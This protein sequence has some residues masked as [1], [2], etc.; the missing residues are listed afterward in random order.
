M[1][2]GSTSEVNDWQTVQGAPVDDWQTVTFTGNPARAK[3]QS[4]GGGQRTPAEAAQSRRDAGPPDNLS[5]LS[6]AYHVGAGVQQIGEGVT[7][8]GEPGWEKLGGASDIARGAMQVAAP[9]TLPT[10]LATAPAKTLLGLIMGGAAGGLAEGAA[11]AMGAPPG[12]AE[13]IGTGAGLAGGALGYRLGP[14][15]DTLLNL[16]RARN[17]PNF[18]EAVGNLIPAEYGTKVRKVGKALQAFKYATVEPPPGADTPVAGYQKMPTTQTPPTPAPPELG[19]AKMPKAYTPISPEP[20]IP[21]RYGKMPVA[22]TPGPPPEEPRPP[23]YQKMPMVRTPAEPAPELT[24][25]PAYNRS[26]G[27][28]TPKAPQAEIPEPA[29]APAGPPSGVPAKL[30]EKL[31]SEHREELRGKL[32]VP[33][34]P[35]APTTAGPRTV[36]NT[37]WNEADPRN[38][39]KDVVHWNAQLKNEKMANFYVN[40]HGPEAAAKLE[41]LPDTELIQHLRQN[42]F[43]APRKNAGSTQSMQR[44]LSQVRADIKRE[45]QTRL[46]LTPP[47]GQ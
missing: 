38:I 23:G 8:M 3:R 4:A 22:R 10:S 45:I 13:A 30:W 44:P 19:Y 7:R 5:P 12:A 34:Q 17:D 16:F 36:T 31:S 40:Q 15:N 26:V 2:G 24:P 35:G 27:V 21:T 28:G 6:P 25:P 33:P 11:G 9:F 39:A 37:E 32:E 43:D 47:P 29:P 42:G 20:E 46:R 18:R 41:S 14:T 1:A